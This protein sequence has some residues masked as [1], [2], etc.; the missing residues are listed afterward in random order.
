MVPLKMVSAF[1]EMKISVLSDAGDPIGG[2]VVFLVS[3][4]F[5]EV[6]EL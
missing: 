6:G 5:G 2:E 4:L 3:G 1:E